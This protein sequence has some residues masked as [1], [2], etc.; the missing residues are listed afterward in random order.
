[1]AT[2]GTFLL[3]LFGG[4]VGDAEEQLLLTAFEKLKEKNPSGYEATIKS[5]HI[6]LV[7]L[8]KITDES[9]SSIDNI[10]VDNAIEAVEASAAANGV[11][12]PV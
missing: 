5:L 12:L 11:E 2:K 3:S 1:M 7:E 10:F 8:K 4:L 6:G 9:K